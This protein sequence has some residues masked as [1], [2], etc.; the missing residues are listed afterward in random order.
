MHLHRFIYAG[1]LMSKSKLPLILIVSGLSTILI[2]VVLYLG[3]SRSKDPVQVR[4][5]T[6]T[7]SGTYATLGAEF[8]RILEELPSSPINA[9]AI[10]TDGSV[11]NIKFLA[12]G[13][14][15]LGFV[16]KPAL[17]N[18]TADQLAKLKALTRLYMDVVQIVVRKG[19]GINSL[20]DLDARKVYVGKHGSGTKIVAEK[21]LAEL[22]IV[23]TP[24]ITKGGYDEASSMLVSG[25]L[26]AAFFVAG[27]PTEAV[28]RA[29]ES[30]KCTLLDLENVRERILEGTPD[31]NASDIPVNSYE[32]QTRRVRTISADTFLLCREG[33]E[34]DQVFII[35]QAF[36]DNL[37]RLMM[38]HSKAQDI[39]LDSAFV[40]LPEGLD[41]H[42]G[43][44]RFRR[45]EEGKLLI[46]TGALG[47]KYYV[48]GKTIK[49]LLEPYGIDARVSHTDG[50]LENLKALKARS[51]KQTPT[52][53]IL[54]YDVALAALGAPGNVYRVDLPPGVSIDTVR[55]M[56]RIATLH[57]ETAH[58]MARRD[59]LTREQVSQPT[60]EALEDLRVCLGPERSGTRLLA[61]AILDHHGVDLKSRILLSVSDMV[62]RIHS[63]EID[64]GF[65]VSYMPSLA[66]RTI[67]DNTEIRLLSVIPKR[68]VKLIGPA[69]DLTEIPP[70]EYGCQLEGEPA[71]KTI[72]TRAVLV[73]RENQPQVYKLTKAIF[74]GEAFLDIEGGVETMKAELPSIRLH[75]AARKYYQKAG[76]LPSKPPINWLFQLVWY[77]LTST[78]IIIAGAKSLVEL[79]RHRSR[80]RIGREIL[81]I[82]ITPEAGAKEL[83]ALTNIR[84]DI[85]ERVQLRWRKWREL[86]KARWQ[87]LDDLIESRI[88]I[89]RDARIKAILKEVYAIKEDSA[90][91][92]AAR[93]A[94]YDALEL[95]IRDAFEKGEL[96]KGGYEFLMGVL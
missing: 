36:F 59:R 2:L 63:G 17:S 80:N 51:S 24:R 53:A 32:N 16:M 27:T 77:F 8:A 28:Q 78:V 3:S 7:P 55:D 54:Q 18:A 92:S 49:S 82:K 85:L 35:V 15:E 6:G 67:L 64:A 52:L 33:L 20:T 31:L 45:K 13:S 69:L 89:V 75:P 72:A 70:H 11:Q 19:G 71:V 60:L 30:G 83:E 94:R 73:T 40:G 22:E 61:H 84:K 1:G 38:A 56:R 93:Q 37:D 4:I 91:D 14:V 21:I 87:Y 62:D 47:G 57:Q 65:F 50:S 90:L 9:T 68:I 23:P 42:D 88:R 39:K 26:D 86:N 34:T 41:F 5:A 25:E 43:V 79:R 66:V 95:R 44:K 96:D 81:K 74:E 46:L 12:K 58:I 29:L 76:L 10:Y 48:L